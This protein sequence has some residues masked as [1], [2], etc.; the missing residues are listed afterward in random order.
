MKGGSVPNSDDLA[1][2]QGLRSLERVRRRFALM[3]GVFSWS[4]LRAKGGLDQA[5]KRAGRSAETL[6]SSREQLLADKDL[7]DRLGLPP[8]PPTGG[9]VVAA[10]FLLTSAIEV[11]P[12]VLTAELSGFGQVAVVMIGLAVSGLAMLFVHVGARTMRSV[13]EDPDAPYTRRGDVWLSRLLLT[14]AVLYVLT[15]VVLRWIWGNEAGRSGAGAAGT[16]AFAGAG[17]VLLY[18]VSY[19]SSHPAYVELRR[20]QRRAWF[21]KTV[22]LVHQRSLERAERR[23]PAARRRLDRVVARVRAV[24]DRIVL[25][26]S[27]PPEMLPDWLTEL[28]RPGDN[29]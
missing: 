7:V 25:A 16:G 5:K 10:T 22:N 24:A 1:R 9:A 18:V 28:G 19:L 26:F 21:W 23:E 13:A 14:L 3:L 6:R 8:S 27:I 15:L 20:S 4:W 11:P 12:A 2:R 17:V 29:S